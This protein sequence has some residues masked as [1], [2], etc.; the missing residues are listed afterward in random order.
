M[1][2]QLGRGLFRLADLPALGSPDLVAVGLRVP[3][4][5]ICLI[6]ALAIHE[7]T[8]QTPHEVHIALP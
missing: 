8:T 6:S 5:V 2:E 7:I 4:G 3:R 1:L